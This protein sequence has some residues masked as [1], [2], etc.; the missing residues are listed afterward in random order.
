VQGMLAEENAGTLL[1]CCI[2]H[3]WSHIGEIACVRSLLGHEAPQFVGGLA[4][5]RYSE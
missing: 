4:G 3:Y 5:C 1:T 2:M